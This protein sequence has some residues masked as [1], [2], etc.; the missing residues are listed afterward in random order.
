M[1]ITVTTTAY[2]QEQ[3]AITQIR[4]TVFVEE[5]AVPPELEMDERDPLCVHVLARDGDKGVGTGRLDLEKQG[6]IGRLAVLP[7]Y[8]GRGVGRLLMATLEAVALEHGLSRLWCHAQ[9]AVVPFYKK[10]GYRVVSDVFEEAGIPHQ[11]MEK[12]LSSPF[13]PD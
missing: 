13:R 4:L 10:L 7:G 3:E 1:S 5:Q 9:V 12:W 11:V 8:R 6:K 2:S